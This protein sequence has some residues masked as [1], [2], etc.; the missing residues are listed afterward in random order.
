[1]C[2]TPYEL[3]FISTHTRNEYVYQSPTANVQNNGLLA[4]KADLETLLANLVDQSKNL[5]S[6]GGGG[7]TTGVDLSS[8]LG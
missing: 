7:G 6:G 2:N 8:L 3:V 4:R 1:M 5:P